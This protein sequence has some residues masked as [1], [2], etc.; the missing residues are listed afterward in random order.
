MNSKQ[1]V[2]RTVGEGTRVGFIL[3]AV[4]AILFPYLWVILSSFKLPADLTQPT[5]FIFSPVIDNWVTVL[6]E[7]VSQISSRVFYRSYN[8]YRLPPC[9]GTSRLLY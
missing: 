2:K 1:K 5:E 4:I 8:D 3:L 9:R 6:S 7:G